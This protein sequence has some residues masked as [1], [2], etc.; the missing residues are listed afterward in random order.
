[1]CHILQKN[2]Q[3]SLRRRL[4]VVVVVSYNILRSMMCGRVDRVD[5]VDAA[6][7]AA[8]AAAVLI[9]SYIPGVSNPLHARGSRLACCPES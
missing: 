4:P 7:A 3:I 2:E 1:M 6:A 9:L 8:A 5:R